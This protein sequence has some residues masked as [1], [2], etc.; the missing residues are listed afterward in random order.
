MDARQ[1]GG[2]AG[3]GEYDVVIV[4]GAAAG[5][6]TA[7]CLAAVGVAPGRVLVVE[8]HARSGDV[9]RRRY[10]CLKL[11][12]IRAECDLP[13]VPMLP[14]TAGDAAVDA[15]RYPEFVPAAAFA[16]YLDR[17][18]TAT[19]A[20]VAH[21]TRVVRVEATGGPCERAGTPGGGWRVA[22]ATDAGNGDDG[23]HL[24]DDRSLH[25]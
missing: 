5:L 18:A 12:D 23:G 10:R 8:P 19:G 13:L 24:Y 2:D 7:A 9:W 25:G 16:D 22:L 6:A 4:G 1:S 11:H 20:N 17:Y 15:A 14:T 21:R 3:A